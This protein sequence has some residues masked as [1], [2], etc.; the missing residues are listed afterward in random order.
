MRVKKAKYFADSFYTTTFV[1]SR[2]NNIAL[3]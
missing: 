3:L 1:A 2:C